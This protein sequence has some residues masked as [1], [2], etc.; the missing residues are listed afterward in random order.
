MSVGVRRRVLSKIHGDPKTKNELAR[1]TGA[2]D[3]VL[4]LALSQL[5]AEGRVLRTPKGYKLH[6]RGVALEGR[7]DMNERGFAFVVRQGGPDVYVPGRRLSGAMH[8]DIVEFVMRGGEGE[9]VRVKGHTVSQLVGVARV[10]I[11]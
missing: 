8:G 10:L 3:K 1:L 7:L 11:G 6:M 5:V 9:I 4:A 2:S